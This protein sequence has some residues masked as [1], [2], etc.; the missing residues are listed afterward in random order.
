M[1]KMSGGDPGHSV[2]KFSTNSLKSLETSSSCLP[3]NIMLSFTFFQNSSI[4]SCSSFLPKLD[5]F[6]QWSNTN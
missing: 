5:F 1:R 4:V 6:R 2:V 3:A